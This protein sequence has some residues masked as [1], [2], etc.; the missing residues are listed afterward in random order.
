[1]KGEVGRGLGEKEDNPPLTP[2]LLRGEKIASET[3]TSNT[4]MEHGIYR[5]ESAGN[6]LDSFVDVDSLDDIY[7]CV[8][9]P[10]IC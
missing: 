3:L 8:Q 4:R 7:F 9:R 10:E 1:M 6:R 5:S 2:S